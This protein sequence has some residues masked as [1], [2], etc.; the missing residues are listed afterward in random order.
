MAWTFDAPGNLQ[1]FS[2]P[3]DWQKEMVDQADAI[4]QILVASV[5]GKKPDDVTEAE[6]TA[7]RTRLAYVQPTREAV[8]AGAETISIQPWG[9]FPRGVERQAPWAAFPPVESDP[10]G[11]FRAVDDLGVEDFGVGHFEDSSGTILDLPTRHRQDEY[12]EWMATPDGQGG[13]SKITFVAEGYDYFAKLF[14]KDPKTVVKLYQHFTG[15][16]TINADQL[17]AKKAITWIPDDASLVSEMI[18]DAGEFN[19]RNAFNIKPGIVHL[20]HRANSLGAEINLAGVSA[21]ARKKADGTVLD[22]AD[23]EQLIC[24]NQG[25]EPNR[26]SDPKISQQAYSLV[27]GGYRYTLANPVGLYIAGVDE[28]SLTLP[29]GSPLPREWWTVVRGHDLWTNGTSR[30]LR[31]E[32]K[33]PAGETAKLGD[34]RVG[35]SKLKFPGQVAKAL[36]VHLFVTRWM[37]PQGGIGP[38]VGCRGTCCRIDGTQ[39]LIGSHGACGAGS[40]LAFPGLVPGAHGAPKKPTMLGVR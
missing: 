28:A 25:G 38:V 10:D 17:R 6:V 12:L 15:V 18:A 35:G 22:G 32:L 40:T 19:P 14:E 8:P 1:D 30:V 29:D 37:R 27:Q 7:W 9:G 2:N 21:L 34:L 31:L 3:A 13:I 39:I 23:E 36:S 33:P 26:N 16:G 11:S 20:S 4:V 5:L 24:C